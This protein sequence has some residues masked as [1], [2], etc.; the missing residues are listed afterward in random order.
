MFQRLHSASEF[1][2][3]GIGLA[4]A[5]RVVLRHGGQ[6]WGEST[7]GE[8]ATFSFTLQPGEGGAHGAV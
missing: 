8:G 4:V 5:Q 6:V 1:E 7:L 3:I 2:G